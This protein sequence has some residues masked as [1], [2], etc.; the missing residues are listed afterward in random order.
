MKKSIHIIILV[1]IA[2]VSCAKTEFDVAIDSSAEQYKASFQQPE[3]ETKVYMD[4]NFHIFWNSPGN[5]AISIFSRGVHSKYVNKYVLN[6]DSGYGNYAIFTKADETDVSTGVSQSR[7]YALY[8][9]SESNVIKSDG[10]IE[11]QL[12]GDFAFAAVTGAEDDRILSFK[13]LFGYVIIPLTGSGVVTEIALKGNSGELLKGPATITLEYGKDPQIS[14]SPDGVKEIRYSGL[15]LEIK[16]GSSVQFSLPPITFKNGFTVE[17]K[18]IVGDVYTY[19]TNKERTIQRNV[20]NTME[21]VN[22]NCSL[23]RPLD[24][25]EAQD[26]LSRMYRSLGAPNYL[27][28]GTPDDFSFLSDMICNDAEG[29]DLV[30]PYTPY[31]WF[32]VCGRYT[33]RPD[34]RNCYIRFD[35]PWWIVKNA[36]KLI[37]G[38]KNQTS[39]SANE[40]IGQAKA[41][42][43]YAYLTLAGNVQLSPSYN[44]YAVCLPILDEDVRSPYDL[45]SSSVREVYDFIVS[46]LQAAERLLSGFTRSNAAQIN[47]DVVHAL[48]AR[49]YLALGNWQMAENYAALAA[50]A[51]IPASIEEV[52]KPWFMDISE[53]NWIWGYVMTAE[54][55]TAFR[56]ATT[57]SWLR[58]FSGW[59]YSAGT[60]TYA[61]I[62]SILYDLIPSTDVRKG[63]WVDKDLYSPLLE[64]LTWGDA[65]GPDIALYEY[66][67]KKAFLP[68]TNVKF[69][70][71]PIGGVNN[72]EDMPLVR[73]EEMLLVQA[74]CAARQGNTSRAREILNAFVKGYRDPSYSTTSSGTALLN[75][76]WFQR[77]VELWGEGFGRR[78]IL[79]LGKPLVRYVN[80]KE[81]NVP[82][83][84]RFNLEPYDQRFLHPIPGRFLSEH[85]NVTSIYDG[86]GYGIPEEGSGLLDGVTD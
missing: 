12:D 56:Y 1:A 6:S 58:S 15:S 29:A 24:I 27:G 60:A 41:L 44:P 82:I 75:E 22:V 45:A 69:G 37:A 3:V 43:A 30:F 9:F 47:L 34:Y 72:D 71:N 32:D 10:T 35:S 31:N 18:D 20:Y 66:D 26:L 80:G 39:S 86:S 21:K 50:S 23:Y 8:P 2:I 17:V 16:S 55:A 85:P 52:S 73:V 61:C 79:R 68:Y 33:F 53:H 59:S 84:Y 5:D 11:T 65:E 74:E 19:T 36:A 14:I 48:L 38:L 70:C 67:D 57:S 28:Y 46:D 49:T 81:T 7:N 42:R 77:R 64:G 63:W 13:S 78:D 25:Q 40:I 54:E 76:I 4:N 83:E 62:N 51:Y